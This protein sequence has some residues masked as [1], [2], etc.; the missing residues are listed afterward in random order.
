LWQHS[1]IENFI[2]M[3]VEGNYKKVSI[4]NIFQHLKIGPD[5]F[6]SPSR[7]GVII[8]SNKVL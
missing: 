8:L 2:C 1:I 7:V 6:H 5:Q 4:T 3:L